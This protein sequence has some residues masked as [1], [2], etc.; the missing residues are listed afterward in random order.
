MGIVQRDGFKLTIVSYLGVI[1]GYVNKVL[2]FPNLLR[3]EEVGLANTLISVAAL[4]AQFSALGMS[5]VTLKYFPFFQDKAR[6]HHGFLYWTSLVVALGFILTSIA[7]LL[8]Q[9]LVVRKFS[10]NS[11]MFVQYYYYL[12]PLGLA[13]VYFNLF[14]SYLRSLLKTVIPSFVNEVII[15]LLVTLSISLYALHLVDFKGFVFI[16]VLLNC[17]HA[18]ILIGYM[19]YL[20]QWHFKAIRSFRIKKLR[21]AMVSF[22]LIAILSSA[23]NS[24]I[25]NIDSLMIASLVKNGLYYTGIYTTVFFVSTVMF[26][27][28]RSMLKIT[29]PM[30]SQCWKDNDMVKME[31][32][33]KKVTVSNMLIGGLIFI[34]LWINIDNLFSFMP[35]EYALG[36]YVFLLI[37]IGRFFDMSTGLNGVITI[38]SD[39]YKYDLYFTGILIILTLL[40][41]YFFI[42]ILNMGMNGAALATMITLISY[43]IIRLIFVQHNFKIQPFS[44]NCLW[45]LMLGGLCLGIDYVIPKQGNIILDGLLRSFPVAIVYGG[46]ALYF[47]LSKDVNEFFYK[48]FPQA[49]RWF[50]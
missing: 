27:P 35:K 41:T 9:P 37:S 26:I 10:A 19:L 49:E 34:I 13:T 17:S 31:A 15:R 45:I 30:V 16:Y 50:R 20:K 25:A 23:G 48:V 2:L 3:P 47:E 22:G 24:F 12:I 46:V 40:T 28:Y 33:Y 8:L 21:N 38:T 4:Y 43:N 1:I 18:L 5:G 29:S 44:I 32:L 14:D 11:P 39:K 42:R 36:K 6:K 7:F